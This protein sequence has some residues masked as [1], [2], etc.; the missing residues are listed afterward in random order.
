MQGFRY[1]KTGS[2]I[3]IGGMSAIGTGST[4]I[5]ISGAGFIEIQDVTGSGAY[6]LLSTSAIGST[7]DS[8]TANTI[9]IPPFG[10]TRPFARGSNEHVRGSASINVRSL[11]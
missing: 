11:G 1:T 2:P 9:F 5:D 8:S 4:S 7:V 3:Q 10:I 6:V